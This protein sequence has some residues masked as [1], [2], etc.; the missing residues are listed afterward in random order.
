[1]EYDAADVYELSPLNQEFISLYFPHQDW[2]KNFG[3]FTQDIRP[4]TEDITRWDFT[5]ATNSSDDKVTLSWSLPE[6]LEPALTILLMNKENGEQINMRNCN[7]YSYSIKQALKK[8]TEEEL[9]FSP[10][11]ADFSERLAK[12]TSNLNHFTITVT[13]RV[14]DIEEETKI[15]EVYYLNQNYPNPFNPSTM[16]EYGL[17]EAGDV[18]LKIYNILGQEIRNLLYASQ[19]AGTYTIEWDGRDNN[20]VVAASGIYFYKISVNNFHQIKK[21]ILLR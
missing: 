19:A 18:S 2:E 11:P 17:T 1:V 9:V 3:N 5:V 12:E 14:T 6:N 20:G 4:L 7:E 10:N 15:P 8:S 21:L 13:E 16:I